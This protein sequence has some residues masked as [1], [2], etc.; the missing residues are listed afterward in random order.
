GGSRTV[1]AGQLDQDAILALPLDRWLGHSELIHAVADRLEP[2][3]N[4]LVALCGDLTLAETQDH[5]TRRLVA[6][7]RLEHA[8]RPEHVLCLGPVLRRRQLHNQLRTSAPLDP[9]DADALL[10]ELG[11]DQVPLAPDKRLECLVD[12]DAKH[13]MD[14]ALQVE[15]Q[16]DRFLRWVEEPGGSDDDRDDDPDPERQIPAHQPPDSFSPDTDAMPHTS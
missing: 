15:A 5:P 11:A 1:T 6:L 3:T 14:A 2:Y 16:V 10:L 13:E 9:A 8:R 4:G 12:I 7:L